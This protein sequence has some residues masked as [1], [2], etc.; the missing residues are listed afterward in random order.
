MIEAF[1]FA[2]I[3]LVFLFL[4]VMLFASWLHT[5]NRLFSR[6]SVTDELFRVHKY[7][8]VDESELADIVLNGFRYAFIPLPE[9]TDL[10]ARARQQI[11]PPNGSSRKTRK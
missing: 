1:N 10:L 3:E 7:C 5:D 4:Y 11:T 9:R 6:T 2:Y 8:G